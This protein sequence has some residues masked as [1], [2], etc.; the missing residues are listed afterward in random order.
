MGLTT[1]TVS[2]NST[3]VTVNAWEKI[4]GILLVHSGCVTRRRVPVVMMVCSS[5]H[6]PLSQ[7]LFFSH[8]GG[9]NIQPPPHISSLIVTSR[10]ADRVCS[11]VYCLLK[12]VS[13]ILQLQQQF[14]RQF[15]EMVLRHQGWTHLWALDLNTVLRVRA[16]SQ[17]Y[18]PI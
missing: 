8:G 17:H 2:N 3:I 11:T 14:V 9:S 15:T 12:P 7:E 4:A 18:V 5:G 13:R 10:L 1:V 16:K 6:S